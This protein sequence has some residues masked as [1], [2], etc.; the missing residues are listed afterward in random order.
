MFSYI[1]DSRKAWVSAVKELLFS[2]NKNG[3]LFIRDFAAPSVSIKV[4]MYFRKKQVISFYRYFSRHYRNFDSW[5]E[6][7]KLNMHSTD[8]IK[9]DF[10]I[11][12]DDYVE[13]SFPAACE[14][15]LHY[16]N[17]V[18]HLKRGMIQKSDLSWKELNEVYLIPDPDILDIYVPMTPSVYIQKIMDITNNLQE[19]TKAKLEWADVSPRKKTVAFFKKYFYLSDCLDNSREDLFDQ[20]SSKMEFCIKKVSR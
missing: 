19:N 18:D 14:I 13:L 12:K 7:A 4:R 1:P 8:N 11:I 6:E 3:V 9:F 17:Y 20:V 10:P 16:K 5:T 2:L 15:M